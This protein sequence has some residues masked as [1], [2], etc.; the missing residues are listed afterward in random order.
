MVE[1][2]AAIPSVVYGLWGIFV[3]APFLRV[4]IEP[5]LAKLFG[6]IPFF[7]R[8]DHGNRIADRRNHS[9]DHGD[10]DHFRGRA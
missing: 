5:A 6:W 7:Q 1:L 9:G 10:A 8:I 4:Y 2:L 3:L